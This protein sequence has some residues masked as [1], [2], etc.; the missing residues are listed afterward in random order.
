MRKKSI[1]MILSAMAVMTGC[2]MQEEAPEMKNSGPEIRFVA[3]TDALT[4]TVFGE[5]EGA[6]Y[7][8]YWTGNETVGISLNYDWQEEVD[9][10][11]DETRT[12][13]EFSYTPSETASTY[14]FFV[15]TPS[16][17]LEMPSLSR[18]ALRIAVPAV[19]KP[20]PGSVDE[21]AQVFY[22]KTATVAE[23]PASLDVRFNHLTAYGKLSLKHVTGTPVRL[24]LVSDQALSG[25]CYVAVEDGTVS[26]RDGAHS[27]TI[28]L[29]NLSVSGGNLEDIWFSC[30]PANFAGAPLTVLLETEEGNT[31][32]RTIPQLGEAMNFVSGRIIRFS[33]DMASAEQNQTPAAA[34]VLNY[35]AYG[36]YIPGNPLIY[37]AAQDQLSREYN[38]DHTVTFTVL[39]PVQ[40]ASVEFSGIPEEAA[41][42]DAFKLTVRYCSKEELTYEASFDVVVVKEEGARLWLSDGTNGFIVKR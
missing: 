29:E 39:N 41:Y 27:L 28:D 2:R 5:P 38:E 4:R 11:V 36:A 6:T 22:A 18:K 20:L 35:D 19:Q 21:G 31:Y 40:D 3:R 15:V 13:A 17:A 9:I 37:E 25:T 14:T 33:V 24:T 26:T 1:W 23:K 30:L 10:T 8:T 16:S 7:P 42:L 34:D 12:V 32:K